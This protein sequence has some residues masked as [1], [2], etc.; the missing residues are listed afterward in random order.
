MEIK[1]INEKKN[2]YILDDGRVKC[3]LFVKNQK[4]AELFAFEKMGIEKVKMLNE[5]QK[6]FN[7]GLKEWVN[8]NEL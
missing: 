8:E 6:Q 4:S 3:F 2:M 1:I 7:D 5:L